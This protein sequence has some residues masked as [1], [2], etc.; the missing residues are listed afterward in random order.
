MNRS[1]CLIF[2]PFSGQGNPDRDLQAIR[3][4]LEPTLQLEIYYTTP[5]DNTNELLQ[6]TIAE[7]GD[8]VIV[9]GGDGTVS[10]V[11][12]A[13][14]GTPKKLGIIPRGTANAFATALGIPSD[15]NAACHTILQGTTRLIDT[16]TCNGDAMILLAGIGFEAETV[17]RANREAKDRWGALAYILAGMQQLNQQE[18]FHTQIEIAGE[19]LE[20]Q[21]GA[22]TIAN[23][24]PPTSVLAQGFGQVI[25]DDG[26]LEI[27]IG[28]P[29]TTLKA[30]D[31][32]TDLMGA[33][34]SKMPTHR[35]D[36]ICLRTSQI[37]VTT[38][39]PEKVVIDGELTGATPVQVQC[40]PNSLKV[41]VPHL[42]P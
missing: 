7:A 4:Q 38:D 39:P 5:E 40:I 10:A 35:E 11:A 16:A 14:I 18:L 6:R 3:Q 8:R 36:I 34:I 29:D 32:I 28:T 27:T 15:L 26:L 41:V 23:V 42:T 13:L 22:I 20:F 1:A 31:A 24:A 37:Y 9:S 25:P 2:N 12:Q 21:A 17:E 33:A 30:L 19:H